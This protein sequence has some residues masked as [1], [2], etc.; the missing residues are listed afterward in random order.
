M[1]GSLLL[2]GRDDDEEPTEESGPVT[3]QLV[4]V[5]LPAPAGVT[6]TRGAQPDEVVV[7]WT[8]VGGADAGVT[9]QVEPQTP[10]LQPVRTDQ[11]AASF[12]G[13]APEAEPCFTVVAITSDGQIGTES[14][15]ACL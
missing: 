8:A 2:F 6:V 1:A 5:R 3:T 15:L 9:Y 13:V 10:G 12:T 7:G 14:D 4:Q 11:L